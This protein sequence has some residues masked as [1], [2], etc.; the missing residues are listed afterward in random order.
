MSDLLGGAIRGE[1]PA[2]GALSTGN[3][4]PPRSDS[5]DGNAK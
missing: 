4:K 1:D 2:P 5:Y 3:P